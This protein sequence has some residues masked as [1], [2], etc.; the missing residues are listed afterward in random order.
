MGKIFDGRPRTLLI[1]QSIERVDFGEVQDDKFFV[2]ANIEKGKMEVDW[3]KLSQIRPF[4]DCH[5]KLDSQEGI[6]EQILKA[7]PASGRDGRCHR[8]V[9]AGICCRRL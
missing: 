6:T 5:L 2:L 3:R 7:L 1:V 9:G 4:Q 8:A